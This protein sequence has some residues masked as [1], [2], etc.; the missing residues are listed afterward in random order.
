MLAGGNGMGGV[1]T[2]AAQQFDM[3]SMYAT[4]VVLMLAGVLLNLCATRLETW[5]LRWRHAAG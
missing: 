2:A 5:L 1:L 3:T 4:L